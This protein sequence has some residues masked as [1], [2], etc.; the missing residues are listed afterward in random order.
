MKGRWYANW[1]VIITMFLFVSSLGI[2]VIYIQDSLGIKKCAYGDDLGTNCICNSEGE[3]ICDENTSE[4]I[5]A[6]EFTSI[7]LSY[8]FDFLNAINISNSSFQD[9]Q[10]VDISHNDDALKVVI[11]IKSMCNEDN[12]VSPQIGFYKLEEEV[13]TLSVVSNLTNSSFNLPC[14]SENTFLIN[15]FN[16]EI[17]ENF[18]VQYQDEFSVLYPA[19]NCIYEGYIR[20]DGDVYNSNDGCLLCQCKSGQSTCEKES[21]CLK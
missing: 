6:S 2:F 5:N 7:N 18:K 21:S 14:I 1:L 19:N 3:K 8:S 13:L 12:I 20:N 16:S 10:F 11:E 4:S 17:K 9:V 15:S